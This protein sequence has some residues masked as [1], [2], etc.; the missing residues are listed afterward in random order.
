MLSRSW[1]SNIKNLIGRFHV[2]LTFAYI[3][4]ADCLSVIGN[5]S[6]T[7]QKLMDL[8]LPFSPRTVYCSIIPCLTEIR[9]LN[10]YL[11]VPLP[12]FI[13]LSL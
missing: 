4:L 12:L 9:Y 7:T 2:V 3:S 13:S 6:Q 8:K 1:R 11:T 5:I 10:N